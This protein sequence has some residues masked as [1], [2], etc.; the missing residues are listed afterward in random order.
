[1]QI[2]ERLSFNTQL[3]DFCLRSINWKQEGPQ[4]Q[5]LGYYAS[6]L[7]KTVIAEQIFRSELVRSRPGLPEPA[8]IE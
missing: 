4:D 2:S 3:M 5:Y 7:E 1:M 8:V 6:C